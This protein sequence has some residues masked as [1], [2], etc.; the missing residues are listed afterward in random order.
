MDGQRLERSGGDSTKSLRGDRPELNRPGGS[1]L[2]F[3]FDSGDQGRHSLLISGG[4]GRV[5]KRSRD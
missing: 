3:S 1:C 2:L 5:R 4:R